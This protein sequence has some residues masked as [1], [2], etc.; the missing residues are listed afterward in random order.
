M[1]SYKYHEKFTKEETISKRFEEMLN[2][3]I[4]NGHAR[5]N[6]L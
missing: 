3:I 6:F 4:D 5:Q 1:K 2:L